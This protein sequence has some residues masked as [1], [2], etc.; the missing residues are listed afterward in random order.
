MGVFEEQGLDFEVLRHCDEKDL[1]DIGLNL[2]QR[3]KI[4]AAMKG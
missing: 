3:M 2:G 4:I 1:K